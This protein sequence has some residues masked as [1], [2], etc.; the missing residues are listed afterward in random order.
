MQNNTQITRAMGVS[1]QAAARR[2][3]RAGKLHLLPGPAGAEE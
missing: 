2:R 1:R 3:Q